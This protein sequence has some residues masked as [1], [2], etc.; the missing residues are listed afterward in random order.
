MKVVQKIKYFTGESGV[1][2]NY[3]LDKLIELV[4]VEPASFYNKRTNHIQ[5]VN[6]YDVYTGSN[7]IENVA[8]ENYENNLFYIGEL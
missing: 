5:L 6:R 8:L 2:Y 4:E 3:H 1:Y 7:K